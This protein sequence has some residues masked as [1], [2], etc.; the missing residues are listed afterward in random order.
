MSKQSTTINRNIAAITTRNLGVAG[1]FFRSVLNDPEILDGIP[2]DATV[3]LMPAD[4]PEIAHA[5]LEMALRQSDS[6]KN[7]LLYRVGT[8]APD[9]AAW[10]ANEHTFIQVKSVKPD[11]PK[12]IAA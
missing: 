12:D 6:G 1:Q 4:D 3:V 5:N 8:P 2:D 7:V 9:V 10:G 11:W